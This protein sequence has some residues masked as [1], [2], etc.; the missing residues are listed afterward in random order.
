MSWLNG[1]SLFTQVESPLEYETIANTGSVK[2][3]DYFDIKDALFTNMFNPKAVH[4]LEI[5]LKNGNTYS[6]YLHKQSLFYS[7]LFDC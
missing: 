5:Y 3:Y 4:S 2:A 1:Q 7:K 6:R